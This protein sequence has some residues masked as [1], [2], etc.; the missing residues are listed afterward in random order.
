MGLSNR[1]L[2]HLSSLSRKKFRREHGQCVIEGVR[3]C[4]EILRSDWP[5]RE[6]YY[7]GDFAERDDSEVLFGVAGEKHLN[8]TEISSHE[9]QKITN[10]EHPQ[11]VAVLADI[12]D[13][14]DFEPEPD[15]HPEILLLDGI[16]DPGNFGTL[17]RSADWFGVRE[18]LA[19]PG[20]V[21]WTNPKVM[22]ASMGA[23]FRVT[24]LEINDWFPVLAQL[25][26]TSYSI[27]TADMDGVGVNQIS[28]EELHQPWALVLGNEAHGVS[29]SLGQS[30]N[31]KLTIPGDGPADSLNVAMAGTVLLYALTAI[32]T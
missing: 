14:P 24:V 13:R 28:R 17:L 23:V 11:G 9:M 6:M 20:S 8:P 31:K 10:T 19:G 16:S 12:P 29:V 26:N 5:L 30:A 1:Q 3:L 15:W 18:I 7:T 4:E 25:R 2:K 21:E 22:R 32:E 27:F